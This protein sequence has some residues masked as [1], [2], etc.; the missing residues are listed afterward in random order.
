MT[1]NFIG[2]I[3]DN[4]GNKYTVLKIYHKELW[5][6]Y[7]ENSKV[8]LQSIKAGPDSYIYFD[9]PN[10]FNDTDDLM[11]CAFHNELLVS[12]VQ[13][14][15]PMNMILTTCTHKE[16]RNRSISSKLLEICIKDIKDSRIYITAYSPEGE[17]YLHKKLQ[18][19]SNQTGKSLL[20][21]N[22]DLG[23]PVDIITGL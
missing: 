16:Y 17:K 20:Q 3:D 15:E 14:S 5:S 8:N 12:H 19:L 21:Y 11:Y 9:T 23:Y 10:L 2:Y 18:L 13:Y 7:I 22:K 1:D 6:K 4:L